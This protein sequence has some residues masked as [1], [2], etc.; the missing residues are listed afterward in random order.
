MCF[1][2]IHNKYW[3]DLKVHC[4]FDPEQVRVMFA[5]TEDD[6]VN[7]LDCESQKFIPTCPLG[8]ARRVPKLKTSS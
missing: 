6:I 1:C 3:K 4:L 7:N 2:G 5:G 8:G